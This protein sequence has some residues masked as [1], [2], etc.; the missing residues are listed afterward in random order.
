MRNLIHGIGINDSPTPIAKT[1]KYLD[2]CGKYKKKIIWRCPFYTTWANMLLRVSGGDRFYLECSVFPEWIYFSKFKSWMETQD[3]EGKQLDKDLLVLGNKV[4]SPETCV[5][6]DQKVNKLLTDRKNH[7]GVW[8]T[9][10]Y[11][12]SGAGRFYSRCSDGEGN[13]IHLGMFDTPEEAHE[14]WKSYKN[15][16]AT[17]LAE[18]EKDPRIAK[19]LIERYK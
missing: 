6:I 19:A 16:L 5:F 14:V 18:Q 11:Q 4:Y 12:K 3:W 13:Q 1:E 2:K 7:S 17:K 15:S 10:V 8:P 9:G